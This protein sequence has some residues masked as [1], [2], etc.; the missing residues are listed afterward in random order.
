MKNPTKLEKLRFVPLHALSKPVWVHRMSLGSGG[1]HVRV[2]AVGLL[3]FVASW[4]GADSPVDPAFAFLPSADRTVFVANGAASV[5][6]DR[7]ENLHL[8]KGSPFEPSV[9]ALFGHRDSTLAAEALFLI[10]VA[11]PQDPVTRERLLDR[12]M[13]SVSTMKGLQVYSISLKRME[14]FIFDAYR[15]QSTNKATRLP[16]P[17]VPVASG[18]VDFKMFQNEEQTGESFSQYTFS[19]EPGWYRVTQT[20][21]TSLNYGIVPLVSPHD[22]LTTVY[23]VPVE[24]RLLV[25]GVT[26]AKT[27]SLFGLERTR[28]A[29]LYARMEALVTWFTNNLKTSAE[30]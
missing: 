22:L 12:A 3:V 4:V 14:T 11:L 27:I 24:G 19:K 29:S 15:T 8:W 18:Y 10:P 7:F 6:S 9:R 13:T 17:E 5:F 28:T 16:D 2:M 20:N 1:M 30:K 23:V 25:Y 26:V 21:L